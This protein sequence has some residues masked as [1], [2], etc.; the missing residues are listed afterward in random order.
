MKVLPFVVLLSLLSATL[1]AREAPRD[2]KQFNVSCPAH[3]LLP[4]LDAAYHEC[5]HEHQGKSCDNFVSLFS[6]LLPEYDCQRRFD[7]SASKD[8]VVPAVW[9]AGA[10]HEDYVHLLSSLKQHNARCLF[11]SAKFRVTL[12]GALAEQF[13]AKSRLMERGLGE[14]CR[15]L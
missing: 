7:H 6:Q 4:K 9:L 10:A 15:G 8:Y 12:D 14:S 13:S 2:M 5:G 1:I 11:G 3:E